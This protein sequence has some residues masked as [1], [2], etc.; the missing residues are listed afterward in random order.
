MRVY[1]VQED[2]KFQEFV[3]TPF[4][5]EHQEATLENWLEENPDGILEDGRVLVIGRQVTT[6]L[7]SV[8]DLLAL[9]REGDV[10]VLELKRDRT[11]RDVVAQALEYASFAEQLDAL[12]LEEILQS[13]MND[14]SLALADYHRQYF[15]LTPDEAVAFNKDQRI[16]VVGQSVTPEIRQTSAF[17]RSKGSRVTCVEFSF[18][19]SSEG[20]RLLS[21]EIVI[22]TEL[23]RTQRVSSV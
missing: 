17:L 5:Q 11:P 19:Q 15:G 7:G 8:I 2:G 22:G 18:F 20:T 12:Q 10:V 21:Q 1:G 13:Y 6:N 9:D 14:D 16:V 3:A 23:P 4:Q